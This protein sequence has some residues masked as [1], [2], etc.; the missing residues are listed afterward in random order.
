MQPLPDKITGQAHSLSP[1]SLV[2]LIKIE[3][4]PADNS[5]PVLLYLSPTNDRTFAGVNYTSF[6][7]ALEGA[8]TDAGMEKSRPRLQLANPDGMFS[9]FAQ[10]GDLEM[11]RV[12]RYRVHP[13]DMGTNNAIVSSWYVSRV[14]SISRS[15]VILELAALTDGPKVRIPNRVFATPEFRSVR[16]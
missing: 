5:S 10:N 11:A 8:G 13:D 3:I 1:D 12:D 4:F 16:L 14:E 15:M 6:A 9:V 7:V 2:T